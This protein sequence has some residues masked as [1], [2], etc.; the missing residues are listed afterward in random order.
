M[1]IKVRNCTYE[2][3]MAKPVAPHF[4]PHKPSL[5]FRTLM[6]LAGSS[7]LKATRFSYEKIGQEGFPEVAGGF[8]ASGLATDGVRLAGAVL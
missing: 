7:E 4:L 3:A 8:G 2:E 1:K 5:L 6:Y